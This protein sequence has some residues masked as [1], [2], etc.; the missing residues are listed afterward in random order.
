MSTIIRDIQRPVL[1]RDAWAKIS[2]ATAH[3]AYGRR[4]AVDSAI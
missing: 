2:A 4:G 3:E 1:D